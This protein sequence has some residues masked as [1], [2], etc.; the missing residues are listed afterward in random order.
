MAEVKEKVSLEERLAKIDG[1]QYEL[2]KRIN[3]LTCSKFD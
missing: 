3:D 2:S 1:F